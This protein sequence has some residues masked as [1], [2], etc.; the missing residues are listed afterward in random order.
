M[1]PFHACH[2]A[3]DGG[4]HLL[5]HNDFLLGE[6]VGT[7][8]DGAWGDLLLDLEDSPSLLVELDMSPKP[9]EDG[10]FS[11]WE[12]ESGIISSL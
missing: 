6:S 9:W 5:W 4:E 3:L 2:P 8:G 10:S 11:F 1:S 12:L 7:F